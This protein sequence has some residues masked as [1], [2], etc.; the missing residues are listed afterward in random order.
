ML[1][2]LP[3]LAGAVRGAPVEATLAVVYLGVF[4]AALAYVVWSHALS[5]M[6]ASVAGSFLYLVPIFAILIG[7]AWLGEV[8][9]VLSL[10]GGCLSLVGVAMVNMQDR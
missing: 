10:A 4:P 1:I 6:P 2:F 7:W 8:P 3:G 9:L 5:R